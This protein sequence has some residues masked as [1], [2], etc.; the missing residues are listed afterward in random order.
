MEFENEFLHIQPSSDGA[1]TVDH[2]DSGTPEFE[3][4]G[5]E[6][7][8]V[9]KTQEEFQSC[10][11]RALGKRLAKQR[12]QD[13]QLSE[14]K[15]LLEKAYKKLGL[16][17]VEELKS[18]EDTPQN[19]SDKLN[20]L[21]AESL[22]KELLSLAEQNGGAYLPE[23]SESLLADKRFVSLVNSGFSIKEAYDAINLDLI[24]DKTRSEAREEL[25]RDIRLKNYQPVED[26]T[27]GYGSFS[28]ALDPRNLSDAQRADIR[29][30]VRR[31]E[32]ITF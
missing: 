7:F 19:I 21:S 15:P 27:R 2:S 30:R 5:D 25:L 3:E 18:F 24:V 4:K 32:R 20:G 16:S 6:A 10:I 23:Q 14:L 22:E 1:D 12:E 28:A 13:Q 31:G 29:E 26:V 17:S 11:D 9:F 8:R